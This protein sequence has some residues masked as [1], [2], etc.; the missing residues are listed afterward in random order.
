MNNTVTVT[1]ENYN[2]WKMGALVSASV[3]IISFIIFLLIENP[4]W[5][6]VIR[7][8]AFIFFA[9]AILSYLQIMNGPIKI[10]LSL[11]NNI[12]LVT[13]E[14]DGKIIHEEELEQDTIKNV[15]T[16]TSGINI[17]LNRLKPEIKAFKISFTDTDH[18]LFLFE[19]SGRPLVFGKDDQEKIASYLN[20][21]FENN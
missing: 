21:F 17:F 8:G 3:A 13:Y 15:F 7:L 6:S 16:T 4:F 20:D 11:I 5:E 2:F 19:F 14:K 1:E 10:T 18:P 9:V 12:L